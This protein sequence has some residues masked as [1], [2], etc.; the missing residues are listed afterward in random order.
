MGREFKSRRKLFSFSIS[1]RMKPFSPENCPYCTLNVIMLLF[2]TRKM[3]ASP[4]VDGTSSLLAYST[5]VAP[6]QSHPLP[7]LQK[8]SVAI[9][10]VHD[11]AKRIQNYVHKTPVMTSRRMNQFAGRNLFFKCELFQRTGSFKVISVMIGLYS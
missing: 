5:A 9:Q 2:N 6:M 3:T 11:A 8:Q 4:L 10:D 7:I 1:R